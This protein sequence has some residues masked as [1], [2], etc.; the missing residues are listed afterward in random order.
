MI[1]VAT[2]FLTIEN[3]SSIFLFRYSLTPPAGES[4]LYEKRYAESIHQDSGKSHAS[5][6]K[7]MNDRT[8]LLTMLRRKLLH[9]SRETRRT[10]RAPSAGKKGYGIFRAIILSMIVPHG[11]TPPGPVE[12]Q[13]EELLTMPT[14]TSIM[15][16]VIPAEEADM[17]VEYG[18]EENLYDHVTDTLTRESDAPAL[19]LLDGLSPGESFYYRVR[20]KRPSEAEFTARPEFSSRTL[21]SNNSPCSF[22]FVADSH[23]MR[24]W[25]EAT[26]GDYPEGMEFFNRTMDNI[27]Q[28]NVDFIILGGDE[29]NTHAG[30]LIDCV[31]EGESTGSNTVINQRQAELRYIITRKAYE[32]I[33]NR[34]PLFLVLGNHEGEAQFVSDQCYHYEDTAQYSMNARMKYIPTGIFELGYSSFVSADALFVIIDP[35]RYT[36]SVPEIPDDWTLGDTQ[37]QWLEETL[38]NSEEAWKFIF[39]HHLVGG[40]PYIECYQYGRGGV[41]ATM[42]GEKDA[43]FLGEQEMIHQM[44]KAHGAGI[45]F[46]GHDHVFSMSEKWS[47]SEPEGIYYVVT[48]KPSGGFP[49]WSHAEEFHDAYDYDDDGIGDFL[50]D[51]GFTRV[52]V[53]G[54]RLT[55]QY[56]KTD[57]D[58]EFENGS[59]IFE[60]SIIR[61]ERQK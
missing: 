6:L 34:I 8:A 39:S 18:P 44:M 60:R 38:A 46:Y 22:A 43:P 40:F 1:R 10:C 17:Y 56:I 24:A 57:I 54:N 27:L 50:G 23:V 32:R 25:A 3:S 29:A 30:G 35:F 33:C 4:Y 51:S 7:A 9:I 14:R 26:C 37:L 47:G 48:G 13:N 12:F 15:L 16:S 55:I 5:I 49:K 52:V 20:A 2:H 45:F 58:D 42:T 36:P 53:D 61:D 28:S 21:R 19:F 41:N 31:F 59:V 11:I